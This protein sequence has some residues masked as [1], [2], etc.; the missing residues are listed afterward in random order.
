MK[1]Q[2][3]SIQYLFFLTL[4]ILMTTT[5]THNKITWYIFTF[6]WSWLWYSTCDEHDEWHKRRSQFSTDVYFPPLDRPRYFL[7]T[8]LIKKAWGSSVTLHQMPKETNV[9][10]CLRGGRMRVAQSC[11]AASLPL[12]GLR[13]GRTTLWVAL[14]GGRSCQGGDRQTWGLLSP[15]WGLFHCAAVK[16]EHPT[17]FVVEQM[18]Q[19]RW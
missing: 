15:I 12:T 4:P 11:P 2:K 19:A 13:I 5:S 9:C 10:Q 17:Q 7:Q 3:I 8:T 14:R 18:T 6:C 16:T 1:I